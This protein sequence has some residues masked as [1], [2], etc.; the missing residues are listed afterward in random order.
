MSTF[1]AT[2]EP[3]NIADGVVFYYSPN[4][5]YCKTVLPKVNAIHNFVAPGTPLFATNVEGSPSQY[6]LKTVPA[7]E[8]KKDG[9]IVSRV[10]DSSLFDDYINRLCLTSRNNY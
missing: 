10:N 5:P 9:E 6:G 2:D 1:I 4:C 3:Q 8:Y 7:I